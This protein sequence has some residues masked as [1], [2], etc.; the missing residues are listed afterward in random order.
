M[1]CEDQIEFLLDTDKRCGTLRL[2]RT[3]LATGWL[4]GGHDSRIT[5][6]AP[7]PISNH[8]QKWR[9]ATFSSKPTVDH[10]ARPLFMS[11]WSHIL[12]TT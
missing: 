2:M 5:G 6:G 10:V 1:I 4:I 3:Y 12:L 11:L 8:I 9:S 7:A